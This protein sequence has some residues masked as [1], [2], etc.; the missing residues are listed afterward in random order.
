MALGLLGVSSQYL[1]SRWCEHS[2][3][4]RDTD[5]HTDEHSARTCAGHVEY[6]LDRMRGET[7]VFRR[8]GPI[9]DKKVI[10]ASQPF[11]GPSSDEAP[12]ADGLT[13]NTGNRG[14]SLRGMINDDA[15]LSENS[16]RARMKEPNRKTL[17][18]L[19]D[20]E[21]SLAFSSPLFLTRQDCSLS[22]ANLTPGSKE[23]NCT[24]NAFVVQKSS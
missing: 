15:D 22:E 23:C 4:P 8:A 16:E 9:E 13:V 6:G 18:C 20:D 12:D 17:M 19:L 14:R 21:F 1:H 7:M 24:R 11:M 5:K 2:T 10:R 3:R